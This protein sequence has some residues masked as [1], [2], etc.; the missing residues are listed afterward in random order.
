MS[1]CCSVEA[2]SAQVSTSPSLPAGKWQFHQVEALYNSPFMD[3]LFQA[4]KI[5]RENFPANQIQM[6]TLLSVKTGTCPEDCAYCPQS[7]HYK[8]GLQKQKLMPLF[9]VIE[10]AK[11]AKANGASRFCM[12]AAWRSPTDAQVEEVNEMVKAVKALGLETCATLGML[13]P[14][15]ATSL[16]QEGLDYYNHNLDTSPEFYKKIITTRTYEDRLDT[17]NNVREAG[18]KVCCGGILGMG[19]TREDRISFLQELANLP[20]PPESV[21]IN[22][23]IPIPGTPLANA[24]PV[25]GLEFVRTIAAARIL[26]PTSYVRLSAGRE[27]MSEEL[28][29]LCFVAG[30]NSIFFGDKLLTAKNPGMNKD[31]QLF[32]KLG[33]QTC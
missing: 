18:I 33:L 10:A 23:L 21:P 8:T 12:G 17:L 14:E 3:L 27:D 25:E 4:Q 1:S 22:K 5:H 16:K 29:T 24:T 11:T 13:T 9:E 6:S 31:L 2:S 28:Q 32:K 15:Q 7:G 26:M 19:E 30:A 20:T